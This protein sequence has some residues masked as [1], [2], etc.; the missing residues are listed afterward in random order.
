MSHNFPRLTDGLSTLPTTQSLR[1]KRKRN[2]NKNLASENIANDKKQEGEE[3][4]DD[5]EE[6]EDIPS[7]PLLFQSEE[8]GGVFSPTSIHGLDVPSDPE[9]DPPC[10]PNLPRTQK[11][12]HKRVKGETP[13]LTPTPSLTPLCM[14]MLTIYRIRNA[15][16][17]G[18]GLINGSP[19][20][21]GEVQPPL[22][23]T[24]HG[25]IISIAVSTDSKLVIHTR[26][27]V[28]NRKE[29]SNPILPQPQLQILLLDQAPTLPATLTVTRV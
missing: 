28:A 4:D 5:G 3:Q 13:I 22:F 29:E 7:I 6:G 10:T 18:D 21:S 19:L 27:K 2:V 25:A 14:L 23:R 26:V 15:S 20:S 12:P 11:P 8:P 24:S 16:G 1:P 9:L 17:W